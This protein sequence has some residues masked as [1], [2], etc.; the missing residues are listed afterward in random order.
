MF[1]LIFDSTCS[2]DFIELL[3]KIG[4]LENL[5][6]KIG[7]ALS[8]SMCKDLNHPYVNLSFQIRGTDGTLAFHTLELSYEDF[9]V[10]ESDRLKIY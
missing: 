10:R 8:S 4:K 6:W 3:K 2:R 1:P 5:Q 9:V 7:V